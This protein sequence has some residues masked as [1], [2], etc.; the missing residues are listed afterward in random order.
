M[1]GL[2]MKK[3]LGVKETLKV[4]FQKERILQKDQLL[5][6]ENLKD[7]KLCDAHREDGLMLMLLHPS[8]K[9]V[10]DTPNQKT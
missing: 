10:P 4:D 8:N 9:E 3:A 5:R 7:P 1:D 6:V 2:G